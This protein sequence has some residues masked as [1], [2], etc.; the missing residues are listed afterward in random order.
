MRLSSPAFADQAE[1]PRKYTCDGANLSPPLR[2]SDA[3]EGTK[4][5]VLLCDD[6]DA[7]SGVWRH[8][9]A[10]DLAPDRAEI[11]EGE[12]RPGAG[13]DFQQAINDFDRSGYGGPC[14]PPRHGVHHYRF[15]LLALSTQRLA[16]SREKP[17][18]E[19]VE[20][21]AHAVV[22]EEAVLVGTYRR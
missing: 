11:A 3:P 1:I 15:R 16:A 10:Y 13:H 4:S 14:P 9:A 18:C 19:E 22:I 5:F 17:S 7:P 6:P 2:W 21:A 12:G 8:W 20:R